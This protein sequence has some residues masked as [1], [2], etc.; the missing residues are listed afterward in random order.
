MYSIILDYSNPRNCGTLVCSCKQNKT[1]QNKTKQN[2]TKYRINFKAVSFFSLQDV[3]ILSR[4]TQNPK[5]TVDIF[6]IRIL[7]CKD[8]S[9]KSLLTV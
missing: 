6:G 5:I 1:K 9:G 8:D 7:T 4:V 2:K 3:R